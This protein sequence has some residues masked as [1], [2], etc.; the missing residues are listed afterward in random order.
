MTDPYELNVPE[1]NVHQDVQ[2]HER[3]NVHQR[4]PMHERVAGLEKLVHQQHEEIGKLYAL[5]EVIRS[6]TAR[7]L[8]Y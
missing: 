2:Q 1:R 5:I 7:E 8:G 3:R 4:M 6:E